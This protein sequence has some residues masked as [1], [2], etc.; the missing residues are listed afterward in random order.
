[1]V[2]FSCSG[3]NESLKKPKVAKHLSFC[4]RCHMLTCL[5]CQKDF[6]PQSYVTHNQCVSELEKYSGR[7][8]V[9]PANANK[10]QKKQLNWMDSVRSAV[11]MYPQQ[12]SLDSRERR[13]VN[14][15]LSSLLRF[16][17][18]PRK[19]AKFEN[20]VKS[21]IGQF[22]R[23]QN[24]I[25]GAWAVISAP[26][27][28][29]EVDAKE[30]KEP[31]TE[32]QHQKQTKNKENEEDTEASKEEPKQKRKKTEN[33]AQLSEEAHDA[34]ASEEE[35]EGKI[36]KKKKKR[37]RECDETKENIM[38]ASEEDQDVPECSEGKKKTKKKRKKENK[39]N[40]EDAEEQSVE[41][42]EKRKRTEIDV[43]S[44][45]ESLESEKEEPKKKKKR[46]AEDED[47]SE[48]EEHNASEAGEGDASDSKFVLSTFVTDL[49]QRKNGSGVSF[50]KL[51]KRAVRA[52]MQSF[53]RPNKEPRPERVKRKLKVVV[54][55]HFRQIDGRVFERETG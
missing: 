20:F 48:R 30:E 40:D 8:Y 17:N 5:D 11:A 47:S 53:S 10:G 37:K 2:Y 31:G 6:T 18:I 25:D 50:S 28:S 19:K 21:A 39:G 54:A 9:E 55:K 52:Y 22:R 44:S 45:E 49:L 42:K 26:P 13:Q 23:D 12:H 38:Q 7:N 16:D 32:G 43:H 14:S 36:K 29:E 4:R 35:T 41:P 24:A 51:E 3:C 46:K 34:L 1:M 27:P 15:L 33:G